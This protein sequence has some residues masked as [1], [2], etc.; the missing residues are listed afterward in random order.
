MSCSPHLAASC[1]PPSVCCRTPDPRQPAWSHAFLF[2][3][4]GKDTRVPSVLLCPARLLHQTLKLCRQH[5]LPVVHHYGLHPTSCGLLS[6]Q[7]CGRTGLWATSQPGGAP[8]PFPAISSSVHVWA[9]ELGR[10]SPW[11]LVPL[12]GLLPGMVGQGLLSSLVTRKGGTGHGQGYRSQSRSWPLL[13]GK[14]PLPPPPITP[15]TEEHARER[16]VHLSLP[17]TRCPDGCQVLLTTPS[18]TTPPPGA[19]PHCSGLCPLGSHGWDQHTP[20]QPHPVQH[21]PSFPGQPPSSLGSLLL[22][23]TPPGGGPIQ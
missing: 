13:S 2:P 10:Q 15:V 6:R 11:T 5:G 19:L 23:G 9:T 8:G 4:H 7:A 3:S 20:L 12:P 21:A 1:P 22:L 14:Q 18:H 16:S 17:G